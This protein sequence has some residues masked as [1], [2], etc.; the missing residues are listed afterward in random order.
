MAAA[1]T[2]VAG[3]ARRRAFAAGAFAACRRGLL[4]LLAV[5]LQGSAGV[6]GAALGGLKDVST[7]LTTPGTTSTATVSFDVVGAVPAGGKIVV[8]LPDT[9]AVSTTGWAIGG[10]PTVEF[11][12]PA[13]VG[14][15]GTPGW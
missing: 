2:A 13:G 9:A 8:V 15:A 3:H 1:M 14:V 12:T 4:L 6:S 11:S 10:G 7:V 5:V